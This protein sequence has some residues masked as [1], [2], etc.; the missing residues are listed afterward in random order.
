[1]P[2][3]PLYALTASETVARLRSG[4]ISPLDCLDAIEARIAAVN[5]ATN[6]IVTLAMDRARRQASALMQRPLAERGRLSGLPVAIKDLA[7]VA[8]VRSTQGS[9]IFKDRVPAQSNILVDHLEREGGVIYAM[10]NTPE[11]GAGASTFNEVFGVTRNPW[12]LSRSAAGS[13]GGAAV[14]LATGMAWLAHGS[15]FGGSLRNPAS[16]NSIVGLRP[17]PGR[18]AMTPG[19]LIDDRLSVEGP[20]ARTVEDVALFLDAMAGEEDGDPISLPRTQSFQAAVQAGGLPRK[21]AWSPDLGITPVDPRVRAITAA[22]ARRFETLGV[23]VEEAHPDLSE[24]P[25]CFHVLRAARFAIGLKPLLDSHRD[26]LKPEI[27]WNIEKGLALTMADI[28]EAE[29]R[30]S[31]LVRRMAAFFSEY[32][33]LLTPATIVPPFPA[34]D[35]YVASCDGVSFANYVE[36]LTITF[37]A[38]LTGSPALSLPCGFTEDGLPIGLQMIGPPRG[39]ARL[40]AHAKALED[41]LGLR[42]L[43]PIDPRGEP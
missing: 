7:L 3:L 5:P 43:I 29:T 22:A 31:T 27:I 23:I 17:T 9:P 40:L 36:W 35:R 32:D 1:M 18:V 13:S 33:L 21:V 25:A 34:E 15:D 38:T 28:V 8:G 11:F 42:D 41:V 4:E 19:A 26:Q 39:E 30:R 16:F 2:S 24:A 12:N 10:T 14:A 6:A 20:M 37:A